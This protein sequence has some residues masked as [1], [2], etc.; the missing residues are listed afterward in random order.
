MARPS[1]APPTIVPASPA[2][3]RRDRARGAGLRTL[4]LLLGLVLA[5]PAA[6]QRND[7]LWFVDRDGSV[8]QTSGLVTEN[9]LRTVRVQRGGDRES[10]YDAE[11]VRR[12]EWGQVPTAFR[13][14]REYRDRGDH[15]NAARKFREAAT[16]SDR[17][18][19][20][21]A[22]RLEAARA[23]IDL[24]AREPARIGEALAELTQFKTDFPQNRDLPRARLLAAQA[25]WLDGRPA[26]AADAFRQLF[27]QGTGATPTPGYG[28]QL[29]LEAG[30]AAARAFLDAGDGLRAREVFGA[31]E[32][33]A[34]SFAA[35][36]AEAAEERRAAERVATEARLGEGFVMLAADQAAQAVPFFEARRGRGDETLRHGSDLG[37]GEAF[38]AQGK[39][40]EAQL[41]FASVSALDFSDRY[42]AAR[43]RLLLAE[44]TQKLGDAGAAGLARKVL[45]EVVERFG[46][47]PAARRARTLLEG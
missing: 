34:S 6:A 40:R 25:V 23:L 43:A 39:L 16:G 1:P 32:S 42:R 46:D 5:A 36:L 47:T 4:P 20:Q 33:A 9:S 35:G 7:Q 14:G 2:V 29:C 27:E 8:R 11:R 13:E 45:T 44:T 17:P 26:E 38:L 12:I 18:V 37:L 24:G 3:P 21:A 10:T 41:K 15:A 28:R 31:L 30:L 22:A 19:V